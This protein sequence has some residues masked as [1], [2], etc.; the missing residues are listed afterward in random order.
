MAS[1]TR[2]SAIALCAAAISAGASA[3][4]RPSQP[5]SM[6]ADDARAVA[7]FTTRVQAYVELR[8][9]VE[10]QLPRV[11]VSTDTG[12]IRRSLD[13]LGGAVR[14]A[15]V[16][17]RQGD[18]FSPAM[19][20]LVR[21]VVRETCGGNFLMLLRMLYEDDEGPMPPPAINSRWSADAVPFMPPDLLAALPP[22]P[23]DLEYR[24]A[25]RDLVLWDIRA[26][27]IVDFVP[28]AIPRAGR[29]TGL[30]SWQSDG[31]KL[32]S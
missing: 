25:N 26:D 6:P 21:R 2:I 9:S 3:Q 15:R 31:L 19:D 17:A 27:I 5:E 29:S 12:A 22:L 24:F 16:E 10:A 14:T 11:E 13:A 4:T 20:R 8:R 7:E 18:V 1:L 23:E 28:D 32:G 30:N